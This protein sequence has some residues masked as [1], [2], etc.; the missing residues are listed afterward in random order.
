MRSFRGIHTSGG[1]SPETPPPVNAAGEEQFR[2]LVESVE[3]YAI[4]L[5]DARRCIA[6]WNAGA[7]RITGWRADEVLGRHCDLF[8]LPEDRERGRPKRI[9]EAAQEKG[10][11]HEETWRIRKD[12]SRFWASVSVTALYD[13]TGSLRGFAQVARDITRWKHY[14]EALR[15]S[16][17]QFRALVEGVKEY[18]LFL[19][20]A[21]GVVVSWNPGVERVLGFT[22]EEIVGQHIRIIYTP[23]DREAGVAEA[24]LST[25]EQQGRAPDECWHLRKD[26]TRF[27]ATGVVNPVRDEAGNLRGFTKVLGDIT[28][29]KLAEEHLEKE[30][31]KERRIA[32]ALQKSLL[33]APPPDAY[34]GITIKPLYESAWNDALVGGDFFDVFAIAENKVALVIGDV[35][36]KGIDAATY[37]AEIKYALR[38]LLREFSIPSAALERLNHFVME[39]ERLDRAHLGSTYVALALAVVDTRTGDLTCAMAGMEPPFLLR[40][41]SG[42]VVEITAR[43]PL[44]GAIEGME[45]EAQEAT[46]ASGD[47]L[48]MSTDGI[49]EARRGSEFFGYDGLVAA[50]RSAAAAEEGEES[51]SVIAQSVARSACEFAGGRQQDDV[52]LLLTR[53]L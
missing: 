3:D 16:E 12:G 2:L 21:D 42:D 1:A 4:F 41:A 47:I 36:G 30:Y 18:A 49:T 19:L 46:M 23:E 35:T 38:A 5:L 39:A 7:E 29:R 50:V 32:Q 53:K 9:L 27:F 52:C 24:E 48:V 11:H 22:E 15:R 26:G 51:L 8:F 37:T 40:A 14:E 17:A 20:D 13:R 28:P 10:K 44:L 6:S 43:G 34:P 45:F 33:L 25:A 31:E